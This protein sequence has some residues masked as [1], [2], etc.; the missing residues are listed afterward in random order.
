[1]AGFGDGDHIAFEGDGTAGGEVGFD[2]GIEL[3][4]LVFVLVEAGGKEVGQLVFAVLVCGGSAV[5]RSDLADGWGVA[6]CGEEIGGVEGGGGGTW[7]FTEW[8]DR[9]D[10]AGSR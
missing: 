4:G 1:L 8:G 5:V 2:F 6:D 3:L 7:G 9:R 10:S